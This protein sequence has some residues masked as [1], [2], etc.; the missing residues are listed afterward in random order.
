MIA[1]LALDKAR[2]VLC[3]GPGGVGKTTISAALGLRAALSGR[4]TALMTVDPAPRLLDAL[5]LDSTSSAIQEVDLHGLGARRGA[6]LNAMRLD[7][8]EVFDRLVARYAPSPGARAAILNDRIYRS[9]SGALSGVADYMAM[10]QL[11][12]LTGGSEK[13]GEA[14]KAVVIDTPPAMQAFDFLDAPRRMLELL[15]SR[16]VTLLVPRG[17]SKASSRGSFSVIDMAARMVL[18]AFDRITGLHLLTDVQTFVRNFDGMYAGFA[19]RADAAQALIRE[20]SSAI[21]LV[22]VA[23]PER[24]AQA[25]EFIASLAELELQ[26]AAIV[27]N[28]VMPPVPDPSSVENPDL[29]AA[30]TRK[31]KRNLADFAALRKRAITAFEDLRSGIP[32]T[33]PILI[34]PDLGFE[35]RSLA[36][37]ARIAHQLHKADEQP[38][39]E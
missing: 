12:E 1:E 13:T 9:L 25:R 6:R 28:R 39:V 14:Y 29:P 32:A 33:I 18:G 20:D 19:E 3:L 24:I 26:P 37:L 5:G 21:V 36:D 30:L 16:A 31:L 2:L 15:G 23:E 4:S 11:L 34:A 17:R 35:P 8:R 27:V 7:P 22:T 10:E 38:P